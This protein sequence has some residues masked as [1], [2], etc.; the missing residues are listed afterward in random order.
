[1]NT[2]EEQQ[3]DIDILLSD[4]GDY[5]ETR[6]T[7][8]KLKAIESLSDVSGELVSGLA[9]IGIAFLVVL[10]FSTGLA[11]LIGHW[12]GKSFY[13]FF[14]IG[15]FYALIG[16]IFYANRSQWLKEPFSNMLIRKILK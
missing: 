13:G 9:L 10:I 12:T 4:A 5:I 15:G 16:L 2:M 7:L 8:W 14:I 6:T 1:M 3:Q 11:L